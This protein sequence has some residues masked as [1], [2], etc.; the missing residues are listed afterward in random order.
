MACLSPIDVDDRR[1]PAWKLLFKNLGPNERRQRH[2]VGHL[3]QP[4]IVI[5]GEAQR[6]PRTVARGLVARR[7]PCRRVGRLG[8]GYGYGLKILACGPHSDGPR[9]RAGRGGWLRFFRVEDAVSST[10][11]KC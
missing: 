6:H 2:P 8:D 7:R 5:G 9:E 3:L 4:F 11:R 1:L 10:A